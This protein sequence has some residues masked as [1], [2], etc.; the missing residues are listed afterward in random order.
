MFRKGLWLL[1]ALLLG[2]LL[3][4]LLLADRTEDITGQTVH[5]LKVPEGFPKPILPKDNLLT[6]ERITL[7]ERLFNDTILSVDGTVSCAACHVP[8]FA[9]SDDR[10]LSR[11][12]EGRMGV[13]NSMPLFN[14]AWKK[15]FFWDGRAKSVRE[16]VMSPIQDHREMAANLNHVIYRLNRRK[17]YREEFQKT[18]GPGR[19]TKE[20]LGL[21]LENYLLSLVSFDSKY[22]RVVA[23]KENL[24][25]EEERG[26]VLFFKPIAQ[27]GA[28]CFECHSGPGFSDFKMR[29]NGLTP[30]LN[31]VDDE[32]FDDTATIKFVT[33]SL[34]NV[35]ITEPYMHDGRFKKLRD[36]VKHYNGK[37]H[38]S[39]LL[40]PK[41][42][43]EGLGFNEED[44]AALVKFLETLTDPQYAVEE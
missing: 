14:L 32:A 13:R 5:D 30:I 42:K 11:G 3:S 25:A 35:A 44:Q 41:L 10:P 19:V 21:A 23:G 43:A 31:E 27:G 18:Y 8:E 33:P 24:T 15:Q 36:V 2:S 40:D 28:G 39:D 7:G 20:K 17:G 26:R 38:R 22:D 12:F 9:F 34:R 29:N 1:P 4:G 16:Q 6:K 37:L